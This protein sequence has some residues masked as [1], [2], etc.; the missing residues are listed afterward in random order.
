VIGLRAEEEWRERDEEVNAQYE[1]D[2]RRRD[3]EIDH[4]GREALDS[5]IELAEFATERQRA[6]YRD[7]A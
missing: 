6:E 2:M 1:I 7:V 3:R 5:E 4:G